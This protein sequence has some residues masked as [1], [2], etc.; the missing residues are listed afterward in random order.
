MNNSPFI[1]VADNDD[2]IFLSLKINKNSEIQRP[3]LFFKKKTSQILNIFDTILAF[4]C[5]F[6]LFQNGYI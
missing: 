6:P 2:E 1:N 3:Q 5:G 4:R